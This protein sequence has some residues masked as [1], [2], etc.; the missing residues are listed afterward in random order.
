MRYINK[1]ILSGVM[2]F[3]ILTKLGFAQNFPLKVSKSDKYFKGDSTFFQPVDNDSIITVNI[4]NGAG[5]GEEIMSGTMRYIPN[6]EN[7]YTV[8]LGFFGIRFKN[9]NREVRQSRYLSTGF[10]NDGELQVLPED[11]MAFE[12]VIG[13][14]TAESGYMHTTMAITSDTIRIRQRFYMRYDSTDSYF[15]LE[16]TVFNNTDTTMYEGRTIFFTDFDA[17][18]SYSDDFTGIAG[19]GEDSSFIYQYSPGDNYAGC[20]LIYPDSASQYG[21]YYNW[22][23]S[24]TDTKIDSMVVHSFYADT[25]TVY[26]LYDTLLEN[27]P[28]DHSVY[29]VNEIGDLAPGEERTVAYAFAIGENYEGL[30]AQIDSAKVQYLANLLPLKTSPI[31]ERP[32]ISFHLSPSYPNPFNSSTAFELVIDK[33]GFGEIIVY[34]ILGRRVTTL[35]RGFIAPGTYRYKWNAEKSVASGVY[36]ISAE[37]SDRKLTNQVIYIK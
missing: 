11:T 28:G 25:D 23:V 1:L 33:P 31:T 9:F 37:F 36:Y 21:N 35:F 5:L 8:Y 27:Y 14:F 17:G 16:Y 19:A 26:I 32:V 34:D 6:P 22:V 15:M 4:G 3:T 29:I 10:P 13:D 18:D 12:A 7:L 2:L 24:G 30:A 20:S